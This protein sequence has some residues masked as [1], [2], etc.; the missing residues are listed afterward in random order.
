MRRSAVSGVNPIFIL[1]A[2]SI[3][4]AQE[5]DF[6]SILR[7]EGAQEG[8]TLLGWGGGPAE[9]IHLDTR[10]VRTGRGA[11]RIER[12]AQSASSF[13]TITK[14]LPIH[15]SGQWLELR[16]FLRTENVSEFA[17]LWMR[18]DGSSGPLQFDN[19]QNRE[20]R[21]T[22][23]WTE[24]AIRLPLDPKAR[25]LFFGVLVVGEGKVWAD[26]LKLL[27]DDVPVDHTPKR[28]IPTTVL[29]EDRE[30]DAGSGITVSSL[31]ENQV[32]N[33][34][35]LGKVWG[36]LKY[37][38]PR[39]AKASCTGTTSSS[40]CCP[41]SWMPRIRPTATEPCR[42]G[43]TRSAFPNAVSPVLKHRWTLIS[44]RRSTG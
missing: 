8:E 5:P 25:Q 27:V 21:G 4:L 24:Y 14:Q 13:S 20:I 11:A 33:V 3:V 32:E 9:T 38:H 42:N 16:G 6:E 15:F 17:G 23:D 26:D 28:A 29:D 39:I 35:V 12:D 7:F 22:T 44:C 19:M 30:F 1:L 36:F 18:E 2:A 37:H 40:G 31:T 41:E 34:A 43:W 10:I